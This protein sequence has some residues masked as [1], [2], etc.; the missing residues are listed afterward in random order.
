MQVEN[1]YAYCGIGSQV[2]LVSLVSQDFQDFQDSASIYLLVKNLVSWT[3]GWATELLKMG[4]LITPHY[5]PRFG[6]L[7]S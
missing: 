3:R 1:F 5:P 2:S 7:I 4:G 6:A